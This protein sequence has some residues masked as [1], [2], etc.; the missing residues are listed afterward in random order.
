[1]LTAKDI[2]IRSDFKSKDCIKDLGGMYDGERR[3]G[4]SQEVLINRI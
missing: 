1:M 4:S 3:I 2:Y